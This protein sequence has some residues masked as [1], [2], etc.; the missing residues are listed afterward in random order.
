L[1]PR[2]GVAEKELAGRVVESLGKVGAGDVRLQRVEFVGPQIGEEIT[3]EGGLAMLAALFGILIYVTLRFEWR[4]ALGSVLALFH[5]TTIVLGFFSVTWMDFDLTAFAAILA[6]IGYSLNDTIVV[7][8]R[9]RENFRKVR[10]GTS[11]EIMNLALN[12]TLSRTVMTGVTTL[13]VLMSLY[14]Y[15]GE[16]LHSFTVALIVGVVF[17]IYSSV[18]VA[19]A[20]ALAL[21][22]SRADLM[23]AQKEGADTRP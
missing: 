20:L 12:E 14:L 6:V 5:D 18:Y 3:E 21:G 23:P 16:L 1:A 9:V 2:P 17:G 7:Y 10:R 15:G 4:L 11:V 22:V 13:L 8:D 19:S